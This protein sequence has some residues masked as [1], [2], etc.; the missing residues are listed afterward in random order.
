MQSTNQVRNY[1]AQQVHQV[2]V[3]SDEAIPILEAQ[4]NRLS[5]SAQDV[6]EYAQRLHALADR[7]IGPR[8]VGESKD[9]QPAPSPTYAVGRLNDAHE[10][11][12]RTR[13]ALQSAVNRLETL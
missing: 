13:S 5:T 1:Q 7:L 6:E 3:N 2:V 10:W 12:E 8:G 11:L 9:G 4:V